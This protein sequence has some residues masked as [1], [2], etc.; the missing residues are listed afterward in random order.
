MGFT[1]KKAELLRIVESADEETTGKLIDFY[2]NLAQPE[3]SNEDL[4]E[5][6]RRSKE[7]ASNP[8]TAIPWEES[9]ARIRNKLKK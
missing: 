8:E 7:H 9:M 2:H 3:F 5:F 6:D 4:F 1:E